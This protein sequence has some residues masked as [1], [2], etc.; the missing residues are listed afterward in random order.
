VVVQPVTSLVVPTSKQLVITHITSFQE[1]AMVR[2]LSQAIV[3]PSFKPSFFKLK[4]INILPS[5]PM[6]MELF[7]SFDFKI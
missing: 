5:T 6:S 7:F 4:V 1:P 2:V 3:I